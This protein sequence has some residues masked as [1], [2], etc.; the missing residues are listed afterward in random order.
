[1]LLFHF[2]IYRWEISELDSG[3]TELRLIDL[4]YRSNDRYPFVAVAHLDDDLTIV[5]SYTVGF[6]Q[7]KNYK[8]AYKSVLEMNRRQRA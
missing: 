7:K 8:N 4:R 2:P 1:M 3:L 6:S 5:N